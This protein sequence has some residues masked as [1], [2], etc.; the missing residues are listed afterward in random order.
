MSICLLITIRINHLLYSTVSYLYQTVDSLIDYETPSMRPHNY[1]YTGILSM[2]LM[3]GC[4]SGDSDNGSATATTQTPAQTASPS[5]K[6]NGNGQFKQSNDTGRFF[7]F[8]FGTFYAND[9][10]FGAGDCI[11][12]HNDY[13]YET[14]NLYV[15][16]PRSL[17]STDFITVAEW[18]ENQIPIATSAVGASNFDALTASRNDIAPEVNGM[19]YDYFAQQ[20]LTNVTY[21]VAYDEFST[22]DFNQQTSWFAKYFRDAERTQQNLIIEE[23]GELAGFTWQEQSEYRLGNKLLV[24][25]NQNT[26]ANEYAHAGRYGVSIAAPSIQSRSDAEQIVLHELIHTIQQMSYDSFHHFDTL[27]RW[28]FEGQAVFLAG[29]RIANQNSASNYQTPAF[30]TYSDEANVD[31]GEI[32]EHYGLAYRY[33]QNANGIEKMMALLRNIDQSDYNYKGS[34]VSDEASAELNYNF[35]DGKSA[36]RPEFIQAFDM[37]NLVDA[38]GQALTLERFKRDYVSLLN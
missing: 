1:V 18:I 32:Y 2:A 25:I 4:G 13:Y 29:Q 12:S 22:W 15:F 8:D 30:V 21:P 9:Y 23:V 17:P 37:S 31:V 38:N 16:G 20:Q 28:F 34:Y 14:D 10:N 11:N 33:L 26:S 7:G 5:T 6:N 3:T 36:H 24:C 35:N 19:I 27:P